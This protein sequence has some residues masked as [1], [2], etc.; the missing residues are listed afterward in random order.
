[1]RACNKKCHNFIG[2]VACAA[3]QCA[4]GGAKQCYMQM[5]YLCHAQDGSFAKATA[6]ER[7]RITLESRE[8]Y[9]AIELPFAIGSAVGRNDNI[10]KKSIHQS[11]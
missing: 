2:A 10:V 1:M 6:Y 9:V 3:S 8:R 5:Y 4:G 11:V 7:E